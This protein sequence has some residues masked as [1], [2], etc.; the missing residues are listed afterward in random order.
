MSATRFS[1]RSLIFDMDGLLVDSEPLWQAS[2]QAFARA[3]GGEWTDAMYRACIGQ[4]IGRIVHIMG[5]LLGF[6]VDEA[7]DVRELEDLFIARIG[8][9]EMKPGALAFVTAA[10]GRLPV[11]LASSSP[12]RLIDATLERFGITDHFDVTVSGQEVPR[13]KPFPDVYLRAAELLSVPAR[14]CVA[15]E[16]SRT[17]A[18]AAREAGMTVIAV[19][20]G[21]TS[22]FEGI[23]DVVVSSLFEART[24]V[25]F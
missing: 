19:P 9:L 2:E 13:A 25:A 4:G 15:L 20:E 6:A 24:L 5:E 16:D 14:D 22:G 7:R 18:R 10:R 1:P 11:G 12:R 23:A 21:E 17:G 3:R 8:A